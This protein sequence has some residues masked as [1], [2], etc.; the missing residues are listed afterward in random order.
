M[1][2]IPR[3][4]RDLQFRR[5]LKNCRSLAPLGITKFDLETPAPVVDDEDDE[6]LAAIDQGMRDAEAGR[7]APA[8]E[9]RGLLRKWATD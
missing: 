4:A 6:A 9:V 1:I 8:E 5:A 2:V 3:G 7:I